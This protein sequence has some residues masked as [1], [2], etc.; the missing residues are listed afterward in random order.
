MTQPARSVAFELPESLPFPMPQ[1]TPETEFFWQSG[2]DGVLRL[3]RCQSCGYFVHPPSPRCPKCGS[4]S[5]APEQVSGRGVVYSFSI[6][7]Q[8]FIPGLDPYCVGMIEIEEQDDVRII[9]PIVGCRAEE[10]S[11]GLPVSVA[12]RKR[13]DDVW[14]PYF[15]VVAA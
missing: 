2:A 6:A 3:L 10:V 4:T 15:R 9:G 5:V 13:S 11:I 1:I 12:F 7:V 8:A 14:M